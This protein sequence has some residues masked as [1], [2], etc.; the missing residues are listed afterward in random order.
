MANW[1]LE[2]G[3]KSDIV[4]SSRIR[5][6]RNIKEIPFINKMRKD[7]FE[8]VLS[9]TENAIGNIGYG[10]KFL[11]LKDMDKITKDSLV[12]KHLISPEFSQNQYGAI[13]INDEENICIMINEEDHIR[14]QVFSAGENLKGN[15]ALALEID[16][17]LEK[18]INYAYN[19][20]FGFLSNCLAAVGTGLKASVMVHLPAL[21]KTG[22]INKM[23]N[24]IS[25]LDM[26]VSG[27]YGER[28][29]AKGNIYKISTKQT[30]GITEAETIKKMSIIVE[31]IIEQEKAAREI[32]LKGNI[33]LEDRIYR[34][35]GI[36]AYSRKISY[37]EC[38]KILSEIRL[39]VD[40]GI[41][42]ELTDAKVN[43]LEVYTKPATLQK[44]LGKTLDNYD[45]D[46]ERAKIIKQIINK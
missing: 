43:E 45:E 40:L 23:L 10:L 44:Y 12:E 26:N 42:E 16:E 3:N 31:K 22:N 27:I 20:K 38:I 14:I 13:A 37:E 9:I 46:I 41:I 39:G 7:D 34:L 35:Y 29:S 17:K 21:A 11:L 19:N 24:I 25:G 2:T 4:R 15:L 28:L 5:L 33:E 36:L 18:E 30:L 8:K 32:L 1:Y 6:A